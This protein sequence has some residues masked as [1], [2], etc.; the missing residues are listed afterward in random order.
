MFRCE[1][2]RVVFEEMQVLKIWLFFDDSP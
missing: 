1:K 2:M